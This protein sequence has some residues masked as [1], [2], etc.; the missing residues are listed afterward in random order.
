MAETTRT[1]P[2][3]VA[4]GVLQKTFQQTVFKYV[5][6]GSSGAI[7]LTTTTATRVTEEIGTTST[8]FQVKADGLVVVTVGD[9]HALDIDILAIRVG[10]ILGAGSLTASGVWTFT[11][12]GTLTVTEPTTFAS[13]L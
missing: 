13:V 7:A 12:G 11:A 9:R 5:L 10:R 2:T 8:V 4:L 6:S 1:N 3:A